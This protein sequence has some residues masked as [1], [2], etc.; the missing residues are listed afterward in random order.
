[1]YLFTASFNQ[2]GQTWFGWILFARQ[3]GHLVM[4]DLLRGFNFF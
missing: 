1:L 3:S 2:G 4:F